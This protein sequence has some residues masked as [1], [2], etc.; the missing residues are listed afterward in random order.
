[1]CFVRGRRKAHGT[2]DGAVGDCASPLL[3]RQSGQAFGRTVLARLNVEPFARSR[4]RSER[5]VKDNITL[6][7]LG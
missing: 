4:N 2:M 7:D 6:V 5:A 3:R 1:M